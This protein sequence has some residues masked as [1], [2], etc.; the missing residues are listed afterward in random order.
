MWLN[1]LLVDRGGVTTGGRG[2][3]YDRCGVRYNLGP[4]W[5]SRP[6]KAAV[7]QP[8][9]LSALDSLHYLG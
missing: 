2:P 4:K 7:G 6:G 8:Y 5:S 9:A 3:T 1:I